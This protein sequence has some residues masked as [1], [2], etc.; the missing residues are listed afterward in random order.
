MG[1]QIELRP[2]KR[3]YRIGPGGIILRNE[4][5]FCDT[6]NDSD[7]V[8]LTLLGLVCGQSSADTSGIVIQLDSSQVRNSVESKEAD[9]TQASV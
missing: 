4:I 1:R 9:V 7:G 3:P 5:P 8:A 2:A 6:E